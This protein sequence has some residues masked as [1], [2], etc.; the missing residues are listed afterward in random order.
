M[1]LFG[2]RLHGGREL[3]GE[4]FVALCI[5]I[6]GI[7]GEEDALQGLEPGQRAHR[8]VGR[9]A[10]TVAGETGEEGGV[11]PHRAIALFQLLGRGVLVGPGGGG[12]HLAG[13]HGREVGTSQ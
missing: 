11:P 2:R 4:I 7:G 12:E 8:A 6:V 9:A 10:Q 1:R 5:G 3:A 13:G